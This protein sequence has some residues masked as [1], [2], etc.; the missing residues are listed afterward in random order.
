MK[1]LTRYILKE[2]VV[3]RVKSDRMSKIREKIIIPLENIVL[4]DGSYARAEDALKTPR[5]DSPS[6][7]SG[8]GL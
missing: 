8:L 2:M 3:N 7:V 5:P 4:Q 1:I 6:Q